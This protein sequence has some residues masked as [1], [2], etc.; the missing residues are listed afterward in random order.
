MKEQAYCGDTGGG[1]WHMEDKRLYPISEEV[2]NRK[3]LPIIEGNY[4][5]KEGVHPRYPIIRCSAESSIF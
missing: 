5:W 3:V 2:C 1:E 4:L